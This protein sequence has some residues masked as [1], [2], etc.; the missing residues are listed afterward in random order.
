MQAPKLAPQREFMKSLVDIG[1]HN[2][3]TPSATKT[4]KTS[5]LRSLLNLINKNLPARVWLPL[6]SDTPH[7]VVRITEEKTAVLNSKDKT[8]YIIYV[9]AVEVADI[10]TSPVMQKL[11]PTLRHTKSEEHLESALSVAP[12]PT[13]DACPNADIPLDG[14]DSN[15]AALTTQVTETSA[16]IKSSNYTTVAA[17]NVVGVSA[18]TLTATRSRS[19]WNEHHHGITDDDAWSQEDDEITAQYMQLNKIGERDAVSQMSLDSIDSRGADECQA[20]R[21]FNIGDVRTRHSN[22]LYTENTRAFSH[23]PEDPSAAALKE[24]WHDKV[25]QIRES[26]PYGHLANWRLLSAIV[27]CGDD[28]RQ[29]LMAT[30][31]LEVCGQRNFRGISI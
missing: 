25:R 14:C 17:V 26:S 10:Y 2:Q 3:L 19:Q 6:H 31:L 7:H 24:P 27:K 18:S 20:P 21:L 4:E 29:E 11:M 30:Q 23:D 1:K 22:N 15:T 12:S 16:T 8:P 9:E 5:L 13:I 28:L